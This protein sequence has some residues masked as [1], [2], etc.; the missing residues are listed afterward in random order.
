[1]WR[2]RPGPDGPSSRCTRSWP[3]LAAGPTRSS[4]TPDTMNSHHDSAGRRKWP[5][6]GMTSLPPGRCAWPSRFA[7]HSRLCRLIRESRERALV[8]ARPLPRQRLLA[9]V[10]SHSARAGQER[11]EDFRRR[12]ETMLGDLRAAGVLTILIVPPGNDAGFEPNR[13][14]LPPETPRAER[15]AFC[16]AVLEARALERTDPS[17]SLQAVPRADRDSSRASP[18]RTSAWRGCWNGKARGTKR[19]ASTSWPAISTATRCDVR[20]PFRTSIAS[21]PLASARSW[22]TASPS[23]AIDIRGGC[24]MTTCS[25]MRC[26][27]RSRAR[28]PWPRRCWPACGSTTP[29]AGRTRRPAPVIELADCA[30]HFDITH[31]DMERG[32]PVRRRVLP[33]DLADPVRSG[34]ARGQGDASR[35]GAERLESGIAAGAARSS[36]NRDPV[37]ADARVD[38]ACSGHDRTRRCLCRRERHARCVGTGLRRLG[39][40]IRAEAPDLVAERNAVGSKQGQS[41]W[42]TAWAGSLAIRA[43][44]CLR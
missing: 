19:T 10:P 7:A 41:R 12:L 36:R 42:A 14:T 40:P 5:I 24:S 25:T 17:Q 6:T 3:N 35:G 38:P 20:R 13:S 4:S 16:K 22:S 8:A 43:S 30:S 2:S 1:M 32:L 26:I 27:P 23:F 39:R 29:S 44:R 37:P 18:R 31:G 34:G 21:S 15:E 28:W 9:D 11:L 33:D